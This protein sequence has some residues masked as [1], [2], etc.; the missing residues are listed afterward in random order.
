MFG[1]T[2]QESRNAIAAAASPITGAD[3][4]YDGLLDLIGEARFVLLGEATHGTEEFYAERARISARL[5]AEKGFHAVAVEA[6]WPDAYR[7]NR[8]VR[9]QSDDASAAAAL[10]GFQRFPQWMWRNSAVLKCVEWLRHYNAGRPWH[11]QAGV[12]GLDLYSL[13]ASMGE[14]LDYLQQV[15]PIA[16]HDARAYF[17]CFDQHGSDTQAYGYAAGLGLSASCQDAVRTM[18]NK[19][20]RRQ[21]TYAGR[22]KD[23]QDAFFDAKQNARLIKNAEEYY[24]TMFRGRVSSWN[25][26]DKHMADTLDDLAQHLAS[27][28]GQPARIVVWAHNSHLGD[29][30]ATHMGEL[31]EWNLGQLVRE[32]YPGQARLIGFSTYDGQVMAASQWDGPAQRKD[33]VPALP[34]SYEALLHEA[35]EGNYFLPLTCGSAATKMLQRRRLQ[36]AIGV[37]YRPETERASHYFDACMHDQF[38]A[39]IQIDHTTA[40]TPLPAT[41]DVSADIP[42]TYP[43]GF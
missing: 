18:L 11:A 16:A 26:R 33:I 5:I 27:V 3:S 4:D 23:A 21:E 31:G 37:I 36:R 41:P 39:V 30:R 42:E 28:T 40:L 35:K 2:D 8:F 10:A 19:L 25:L 9:G 24:R 13:H 20:M 34:G 32:R 1:V 7:V 22:G 29:A 14:V 15:D 43:E 6:D 38:D 17:A 12:Y